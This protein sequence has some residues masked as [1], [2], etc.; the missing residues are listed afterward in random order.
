MTDDLSDE[1]IETE[2]NGNTKYIHENGQWEVVV[3]NEGKI[4]TD[5]KN[6]GTYNYY[7][8][9]DVTKPRGH[10]VYDVDPYELLGNNSDDPTTNDQRTQRKK[11]IKTLIKEKATDIGTGVYQ[12]VLDSVL[13]PN[14][15]GKGNF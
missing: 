3:D 7:S 9:F 8:P 2:G 11:Y 15:N 10:G 4:V 6:K 13:K 14:Y 5:P 1:S 12:K